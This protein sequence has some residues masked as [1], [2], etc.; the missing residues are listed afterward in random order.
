MM[1][2]KSNLTVGDALA[3]LIT[4]AVKVNHNVQSKPVAVLWPDPD[5]QWSAAIGY[6]RK[7][8]PSLVTIGS[9]EPSLAQG[10]AIWLKCA[11]AGF[12]PEVPVS[13]SPAVVYLPGISRSDMRAIESC[14]RDLQPLAELQYRGVFWSQASGRD[15]T[16]SAFLGSKSGGLGLDVAQNKQTQEALAQALEAGALLEQRVEELSG[17]TINAEWLLSLLAPNPVRDLLNWMNDSAKM[18]AESDAVR[19]NVFQKRC[20]ADY[21]FDPVADGPLVAAEHLAQAKG[22]WSAIWDAYCDAYPS[23]ANVFAL[24]SKVQA[25][26]SGLF[27]DAS[28]IAN[29]PSANVAREDAL[30]RQLGECAAMTAE[31]ARVL[32]LDAEREHGVRRS[33]LWARM[34]LSPLAMALEHLAAVASSI[35]KVPVGSTPDQ[36][37]KS[38]SAGPWEVD[39]AALRALEVV[40]A[41]VDLAAVSAALRALYLPWLESVTLRLQEAIQHAHGLGNQLPRPKVELAAGTCVVFVDGLRY[42][43]ATRLKEKLD[44]LGE[45][46]LDAQWTSMPSV[47][48]SGKAWCSPVAS[49]VKGGADD[50]EFEPRVAADEKPLSSAN[51]RKLLAEHG[52]QPLNHSETGDPSGRA[53]VEC[54]DLDHYGHEHGVRLA[55]D[56]ETQLAQIVERITELKQAGWRRF[57]IVTDHGWLL[58]PGGL[59]KSELFRHQTETRWGR[60]AVLKDNAHATALTFGWDWCA[61]VQIAYAPGVSSFIGGAEY[62]HGGLSFQECLVPVLDLTVEQASSEV[63]GTLSIAATWKGLR[64]VVTVTPEVSG[65]HA[66]LRTKPALASSSIA[67]SPKE[68]VGGKA[69][70]AVSDDSYMGSAAVIVLINDAGEVIQ[71]AATTVGGE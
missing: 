22:S 68:L 11:V 51:F 39:A 44:L 61:Q 63:P 29:Y 25:P 59:P 34:G 62:T 2:T 45:A 49:A 37:A 14:S 56:L 47:T 17:R 3:A 55:R 9:Y 70:L 19:W 38:Y 32:V 1:A 7:K 13:D 35:D 6:L 52:F 23:F 64:C 54:G 27:D 69:N 60:C 48:A 40:H 21:G 50:L 57:R 65:L 41:K 67:A 15:W 28:L 66:D 12:I 8:I 42:D 4:D 26:P 18:Q 33:W 30:R 58:L 31:E 36:L 46:V 43:V 53:W 10:P 24:L 5:R 20:K 71:K 16:L